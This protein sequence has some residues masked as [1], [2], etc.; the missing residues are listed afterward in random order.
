MATKGA[1]AITAA[2]SAILAA[3]VNRES[4]RLYH[5][6]GNVAYLTYGDGPAVVL[7]GDILST[8]FN[9]ITITG[10]DA[11]KAIHAICATAE[12]A[13]GSYHTS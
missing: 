13:V 9:T 11:R 8:T 7:Q 3:D 6:S 5:V 2:D 10:A 1:L 4:V 12:S